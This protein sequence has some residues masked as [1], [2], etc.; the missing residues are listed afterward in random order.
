M[1]IQHSLRRSRHG[2]CRC[3]PCYRTQLAPQPAQ[4]GAPPAP[5]VID[6]TRP[7]FAYPKVAHY[8]GTGSVC[9]AKGQSMTCK[10]AS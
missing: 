10:K 7:V 4:P 8:T 3:S 1:R 5:A 6:R 2:R 9:E